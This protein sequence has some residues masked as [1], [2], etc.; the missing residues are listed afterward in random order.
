MAEFSQYYSRQRNV[1]KNSDR[2]KRRFI[3][4]ISLFFFLFMLHCN[5]QTILNGQ[6][7]RSFKRHCCRWCSSD[8]N[9]RGVKNLNNARTTKQNTR[10]HRCSVEFCENWKW[11]EWGWKNETLKRHTV[12]I[13]LIHIGKL[14]YYFFDCFVRCDRKGVKSAKIYRFLSPNTLK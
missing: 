13:E 3:C 4:N 7:L 11:Q 10:E 2:D 6:R 12:D 1:K 8:F 9:T 5:A 14:R